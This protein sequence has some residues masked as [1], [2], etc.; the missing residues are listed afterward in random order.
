MSNT[1]DAQHAHA[2]YIKR[3]QTRHVMIYTYSRMW[4][5]RYFALFFF[6]CITDHTAAHACGS[7]C[8]KH[9]SDTT[10]FSM[11]S[12]ECVCDWVYNGNSRDCVVGFGGELN[13]DNKKVSTTPQQV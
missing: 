9:H 13:C 4:G 1:L 8:S 12:T 5:M 7:Y 11:T 2:Q 3:K 6:T 10:C